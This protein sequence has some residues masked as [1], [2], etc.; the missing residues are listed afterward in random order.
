GSHMASMSDEQAE[1]RAFLSEEMIAEFKAA[2]DMFDADGGGEISAK[3]FGTV[4]R[5]NNVPVDPRVQEYVKRLTDQDGSGTISFEEFLVL[6][7]K[8]MKQ[9]A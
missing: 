4:A 1:A 5:M 9:D 7:V 3:A 6:M 8:S 2:F